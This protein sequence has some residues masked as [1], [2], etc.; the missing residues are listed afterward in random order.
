MA[1]TSNMSQIYIE[2]EEKQFFELDGFFSSITKMN[3]SEQHPIVPFTLSI[4]FKDL[5]LTLVIYHP[6][7]HVGQL[8]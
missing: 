4:R 2:K 6:T 1:I 5:A 7:L 3:D 8:S